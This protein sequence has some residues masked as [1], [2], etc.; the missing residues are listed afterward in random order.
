MSEED[1]CDYRWPLSNTA[2]ASTKTFFS[3]SLDR[4]VAEM[5]ADPVNLLAGKRSVLM[6]FNFSERCDTAINLGKISK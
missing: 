3:T 6:I 4:S 2:A 1:L 5:F